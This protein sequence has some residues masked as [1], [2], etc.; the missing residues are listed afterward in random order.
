[1]SS[2]L[3]SSRR[4]VATVDEQVKSTGLPLR[5]R[6]PDMVTHAKIAAFGRPRQAE[7]WVQASLTYTVSSRAVQLRP[8]ACLCPPPF[9]L[10]SQPL[11]TQCVVEFAALTDACSTLLCLSFAFLNY[12]AWGLSLGPLHIRVLYY[13]AIVPALLFF[14]SVFVLMVV[15][16]HK[17]SLHSFGCSKTR[18]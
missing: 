7:L 1:M 17:V 6:W 15:V 16:W 12:P 2:N 13:W 14:L 3:I 18:S 10:K 4:S 5:T 9:F 8:S 11:K